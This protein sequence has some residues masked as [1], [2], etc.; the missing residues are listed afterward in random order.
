MCL[1]CENE[2]EIFFVAKER[3]YYE[4]ETEP[5]EGKSRH[6]DKIDKMK[7]VGEWNVK[8]EKMTNGCFFH[9]HH[10]EVADTEAENGRVKSKILAN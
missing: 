6:S 4:M 2:W 10:H 8:R 5:K 9:S 1:V 7:I 3:I